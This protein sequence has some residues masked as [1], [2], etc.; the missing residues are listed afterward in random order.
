METVV[1]ERDL[2]LFQHL[3]LI[4]NSCHLT[5]QFGRF[6]LSALLAATLRNKTVVCL[7]LVFE[8][9]GVNL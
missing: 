8:G 9:G 5:L 6:Q 7:E 4:R 3:L 2:K 1:K